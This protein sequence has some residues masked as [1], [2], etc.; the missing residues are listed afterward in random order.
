MTSRPSSPSSGPGRG[1]GGGHPSRTPPTARRTSRVASA[2]PQAKIAA[3]KA[4]LTGRAAILLLVLAVL[5]VS[6]ASSMRAWL[7]Q[8]SQI[9]SLNAEIA[10]QRADVADLQEAKR[11]WHDPAYIEAQARLRFGWVLPGE[12]GYRVLGADGEMLSDGSSELTNPTT[13]TPAGE[14]EWWETSWGSVVA[15]GEEPKPPDRDDKPGQRP[16]IPADRIA[17][18]DRGRPRDDPGDG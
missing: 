12:T 4:K 7:D 11:R 16:R 14:P 8:R 5:G 2:P 15:A 3:S 18:E 1:R 9:N 6:Y 10:E 17:E 13:G